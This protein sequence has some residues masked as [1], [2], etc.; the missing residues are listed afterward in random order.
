MKR[1]YLP[2]DLLQELDANGIDAVDIAV[3]AHQSEERDAL[4]PRPRA[5]V[6]GD[7][8]CGWMGW[9]CVLRMFVSGS[10]ISLTSKSCEGSGTSHNPSRMT[11]F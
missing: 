8:R 4:S 5:A 3:Q 9:T 6:P 7:R 1:D 11:G 10:N 2:A